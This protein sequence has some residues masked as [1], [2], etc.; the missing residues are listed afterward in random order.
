M[1]VKFGLSQRKEHWLRALENREL[2]EDGVCDGQ[3]NR[4]VQKTTYGVAL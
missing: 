3:G 1:A 2:A 4:G